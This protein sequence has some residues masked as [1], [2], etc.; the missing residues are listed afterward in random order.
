MLSELLGCL[1]DTAILLDLLEITSCATGCSPQWT[2]LANDWRWPARPV[3]FALEWRLAAV[4]R[5]SAARPFSGIGQS[6]KRVGAGGKGHGRVGEGRNWQRIALLLEPALIRAKHGQR[7][8][9]AERRTGCGASSVMRLDA[10]A[11]A[12]KPAPSAASS[13][14][15]EPGSGTVIRGDGDRC[16]VGSQAGGVAVAVRHRS[17]PA[18]PLG[19]RTNMNAVGLHRRRDSRRLQ[20]STMENR[21]TNRSHTSSPAG[22]PSTAPEV[23]SKPKINVLRRSPCSR[24]R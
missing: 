3:R 15:T 11:N 19:G 17:V 23:V 12:M 4:H 22:R 10:T 14:T 13:S 24:R 6:A 16:G 21:V 7:S 20:L 8:R 1:E 5:S 2:H 9:C 18:K